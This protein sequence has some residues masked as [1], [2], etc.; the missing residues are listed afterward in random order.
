MKC[1]SCKLEFTELEAI[2]EKSGNHLKA[3]CPS[4]K[5]YV[6]FLSQSEPC[7]DDVM[8]FGKYKGKTV[9]KIC[10][11]DEEY[12]QWASDNLTGRF[13]KS[14]QITSQAVFNKKAKIEYEI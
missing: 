4:C 1:Q 8:P 3:S 6:K 11:E 5:R 2:K 7:G 12:G 10:I 13:Q 14:F 9:E